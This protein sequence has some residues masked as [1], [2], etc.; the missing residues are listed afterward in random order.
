MAADTETPRFD[1]TAYLHRIGFDGE[2]APTVETL[3]RVHLLHARA[4]P[5]ENV[6]VLLRRPIG[7]GPQDVQQKLVEGGRGGWCF[8]QNLLFSY[9]LEA[10]GFEV[11][12][13]AARVLS[14]RPPDARVPRTHMLVCVEV[15]GESYLGDVGFGGMTMTGPI[16]LETGPAQSTPHEDRRLLSHD[17]DYLMQ[18]R[19][20][21]EWRTLY[22]F[23]LQEQLLPD[24]QV[25]NWYLS[26]YPGSHFL[27]GLIAARPTSRGRYALRNN[28]LAFHPTGGETERTYITSP[29][30][31]RETL[32][33]TFRLKVPDG[34]EADALLEKAAAAPRDD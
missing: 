22:R 9:A 33:E 29:D 8:E 4:F 26:N 30:E 34:P 24:Y 23:D 7:L 3:R 21:D 6:D 10:M 20:S 31:L 25:V 5:F 11:R 19:V 2:P 17:G 12:G 18:A 27:D 1:L 28:R 15:E 13:L 14:N 32:E 16:R